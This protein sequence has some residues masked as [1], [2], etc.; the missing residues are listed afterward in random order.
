MKALTYLGCTA[1][2][3]NIENLREIPHFSKVVHQQV[4]SVTDR[5]S[6]LDLE[7]GFLGFSSVSRRDLYA[8]TFY[9]SL[10]WTNRAKPANILLR[11]CAISR[12]VAANLAES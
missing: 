11:R 7:T 1:M 5:I 4:N 8:L 3:P 10:D 2:L 9:G 12:L 6:N